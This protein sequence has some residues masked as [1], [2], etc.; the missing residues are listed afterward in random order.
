MT[1]TAQKFLCV[2]AVAVAGLFQIGSAHAQ[3]PV[4]DVAHI[5]TNKLAWVQQYGQLFTDYQ[6]QISQ[7]QNQIQDMQQQLVN[8]AKFEGTSGYR[9]TSFS[10]RS[11]TEFVDETCGKLSG[12]SIIGD[13][14]APPERLN[15]VLPRQYAACVQLVRAENRR[16]NV[17]AKTLETIRERDQQIAQLRSDSASASGEDRGRIA[18]NNNSIAQLEA[19]HSLDVE[20]AQRTLQAYE[21]LINA[22]KHEMSRAAQAA[23]NDKERRGNP[24]V[25]EV[26]RYGA[27]KLALEGARARNR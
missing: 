27:L 14:A 22:L 16:Y 6:N 11:E 9:D 26:I 20:N 17:M 23:F 10:Q 5:T 18:R 2:V 19:Q 25:G 15:Q 1:Y 4:T 12:G 8:G 24:L 7:I 3:I 21:T 13:G